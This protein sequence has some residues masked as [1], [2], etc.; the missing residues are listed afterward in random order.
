[1]HTGL[2]DASRVSGDLPGTRVTAPAPRGRPSVAEAALEFE[3]Y[4]L[5]LLLSEMGKTVGSGGL[6]SGAGSGAYQAMLEDA[7]ARRAA[8]AGTFGLARQLLQ[9]WEGSR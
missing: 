9:A 3:A 1:M 4:V 2:I 5:R 7:L 6:F 8:E